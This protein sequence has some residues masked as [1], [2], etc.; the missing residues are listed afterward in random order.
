M[1]KLNLE[2]SL[3][4]FNT[5][6]IMHNPS[7]IDQ[8]QLLLERFLNFGGDD[9]IIPGMASLSFKIELSSTAN[10]KRSLVSNVWRAIMKKLAVKVKGNVILGVDN[11]D[12]F[13]CYRDLWKTAPEKWNAVRQGMIHSG[14]CTENGIK[15]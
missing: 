8:N 9:V 10:H 2:S 5:V 11:F 3:R 6:I 4:T 13:A 15:L 12:V 14:G 1:E 7:E